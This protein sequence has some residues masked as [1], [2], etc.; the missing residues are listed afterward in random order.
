MGVRVPPYPPN[1]KESDMQ[2]TKLELD[3]NNRMLR[4]GF[5]KNEGNWFMRV[6]LW[7][8]GYRLTF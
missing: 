4:A 1:M 7:W 8:V 5:G 3:V 6:D 2:I